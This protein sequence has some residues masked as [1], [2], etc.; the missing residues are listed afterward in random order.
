[1]A[2]GGSRR[3]VVIALFANL[4]I[5][6]AK[7]AAAIGTRSGSMMAESIHSFADSGNQALLL[8]GDS[9]AKLPPDER[10][11]MGYGRE[12]YFWAILVAMLLF[13]LGGVFSG[14]EGFH[15]LAH[16]EPL[17][18]VEWALGVLVFAILLEAGSLKAAWVECR[19]VR[20]Q[21]PLFQWA[22]TTGDVNLLVVVFEDLAAML[23]LVIA[24]VALGIAWLTGSPLWDA[25][26][27]LVLSALLL[28]VAWFLGV[29]V[30]RLI[31]GHAA[32]PAL[33]A[34][35]ESV[36]E[37]HG[38]KVLRLVAVWGGPHQLTVAVKVAPA[39]K[40]LSAMQLMER[41]NAAE[42]AV[43]AAVPDV[44]MQFSEP[45]PRD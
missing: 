8:V 33:R 1:M 7:L 23:G 43:R 11:P 14:Y 18:H 2:H 41:I 31:T 21:Q 13:T 20:G 10:H 40:R 32:E 37:A 27:S 22:R 15:K 25:V 39:E 29:Q 12:A 19:R 4:G 24:L 44:T 17:H 9:R 28:G 38:F 3:V 45:D 34:R 35:L 42:V 36:W 26:G 6:I 16:P 5:A 30:K